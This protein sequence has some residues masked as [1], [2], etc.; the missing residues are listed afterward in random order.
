MT[1]CAV[2]TSSKRFNNVAYDPFWRIC[3]D[4]WKCPSV[5]DSIPSSRQP[6]QLP[7]KTT[8]VSKSAGN[9]PSSQWNGFNLPPSWL[10]PEQSDS[11]GGPTIQS[12]GSPLLPAPASKIT[13]CQ[14]ACPFKCRACIASCHFL[15]FSYDTFWF[16]RTETDS[17]ATMLVECNGENFSIITYFFQFMAQRHLAAWNEMLVHS[18]K[19]L[20][21]TDTAVEHFARTCCVV[22]G[23]ADQRVNV[24]K[25][26]AHE[27]ITLCESFN[28]LPNF[29]YG[30]EKKP[31]YTHTHVLG[32]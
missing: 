4:A 23:N 11:L 28:N 22:T 21:F 5:L 2:T 20:L 3:N 14:H 18:F 6:L 30:E 13:E 29:W 9:P 7:L 16:C 32:L 17:D 12:N 27:D 19:M 10:A 26:H 25:Y 31:M 8:T 24:N 15:L 1:I